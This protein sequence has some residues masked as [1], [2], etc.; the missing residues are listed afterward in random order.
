MTPPSSSRSTGA[1][2]STKPSRFAGSGLVALVATGALLFTATPAFAEEAVQQT[3]SSSSADSAPALRTNADPQAR[4]AGAYYNALEGGE[5]LAR[6]ESIVS[7]DPGPAYEFVMQADG[8]AVTYGPDGR[9]VYAT[10][11]AGRGDHLAMQTDGN[12]VIY[13]ADDRPVWSTGTNDEPGAYLIIQQD[14]NL[15]VSR[16]NG[17][18][19][20][21]S[22][23]NGR[24]AEP[25]TDT[26]FTGETL[27][28]GHRLT[29][30]DGRFRA[31][32]QTDGNFVGYGPQG[33]VWTTGTRGAGNR[34]VLQTDG[35]AVIYG[36]DGSVQWSSGTRGSDLRLGINNAG[37]LIIVDQ[38]DTVLWTSQAQLPGSSLYAE[39]GLAAGSLLRSANGVYR[40][41]MQGDGNFVVSGRSGPIWSTVTS[42][43]GSSFN[44]YED[45]F[46]AVVRGDGAGTWTVTPRAGAVAPFRLVM[47]DD[48]NLVEYDG[49]NQAVW[50]S[51]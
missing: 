8:N 35:N 17:S 47:Q 38:V 42:G 11:T 12:V 30:A 1:S 48:G 29:S 22:S 25:A 9:V 3:L 10:G 5:E 19:A 45:G 27:R 51:R 34:L 26:L 31:E 2:R 43:A 13:S 14:G 49:R 44:L 37:S 46:M 20:W 23:V 36:P 16:E 50:A 24:I 18:P 15:V 33:V 40:A 32:M 7:D 28:G 41:V 21:A 39:N 6:G 4:A